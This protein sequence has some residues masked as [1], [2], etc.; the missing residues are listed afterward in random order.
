LR[1]V[2]QSE[3][4]VDRNIVDAPIEDLSVAARRVWTAGLIELTTVLQPARGADVRS[5]ARLRDFRAC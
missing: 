2:V 4:Y 5:T 3:R 1:N